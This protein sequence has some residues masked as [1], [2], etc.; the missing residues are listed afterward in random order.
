NN[1]QTQTVCFPAYQI[2]LMSPFSGDDVPAYI[3]RD[4]IKASVLAIQ[5]F[6][7]DWIRASH[8]LAI[9]EVGGLYILDH[10]DFDELRLLTPGTQRRGVADAIPSLR[11]LPCCDQKQ[12]SDAFAWGYV[13]RLS[14]DYTNVFE[15][16]TLTPSLL[17]QHDVVGTSPA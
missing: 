4:A 5:D 2:D 13:L 16:F 1:C 10:P 6:Q 14:A 9:L 7:A 8:L 17:W 11:G 15:R 12:W 3:Q